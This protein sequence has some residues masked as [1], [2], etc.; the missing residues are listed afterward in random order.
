MFAH[1]DTAEQQLRSF[2][3][4]L[5]PV[6]LPP[7]G[8]AEAIRQ[9]TRIERL[10]SGARL[11]L[12]RRIDDEDLLAKDGV[13]N[14][15]DWLAGETGQSPGQAAKDLEASKRLDQLDATDD[16]LRDGELS[17]TQAHAVTDAAS[18]DP[19]A[20][21]DLLDTARRAPVPELQRKAKRVKAAAR[22]ETSKH[23]AAHRNRSL[24]FGTDDDTLEGWGH[25]TGP[26]SVVAELRA[27]L[28]PFADTEF[29]RARAEGRRESQGA[30]WFD[31][32][33]AAIRHAAG[34][35][36]RATSA[37]GRPAAR[38]LARVD[39]PAVVRGH[40]LAGETCEIDGL[41]PVPV[42]SLRDLLPDAVI[43]L[44]LTDGQDAWNVAH[45]GRRANARQQVV[46]D[47]LGVGCTNATCP[48][49]DH[50]QIDHRV[51]WAQVRVTELVNLDWLCPHCHTSS[52]PTRVGGWSRGEAD[53]DS[54]RPTTRLRAPP[55]EPRRGAIT[56]AA[57][58]EAAVRR[59]AAPC[60]VRRS[61]R[62][63]RPP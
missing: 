48:H 22:D 37:A 34:A 5:R 52:R 45:L 7:E 14:A 1:L 40:T 2:C 43:E 51:D 54:C 10:A 9:L 15:A 38:I 46:L 8:A 59:A 26:A 30:Y 47:W 44:I 23:E 24:R 35:G 42:A 3:T 33:V 31:G 4:G 21:D 6:D 53:D 28:R 41:G 55:P 16:A 29:K 27:L 13:R 20:E 11:R 17:P 36:D 25:L 56:R 50:L 61:G 32:L 60:R 58:P 12:A 19:T 49:T 63:P 18:A 39:V 57:R 62:G